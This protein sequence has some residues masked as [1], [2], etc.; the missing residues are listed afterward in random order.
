MKIGVYFLQFEHN[1]YSLCLACCESE[2]CH[3]RILGK[4]GTLLPL[5]CVQW[6]LFM[7]HRSTAGC[8]FS[9]P[10]RS[11]GASCCPLMAFPFPQ[12]VPAG[13]RGRG[14]RSVSGD[15]QGWTPEAGPKKLWGGAGGAAAPEGAS[16]SVRPRKPSGRSGQASSVRCDFQGTRGGRAGQPVDHEPTSVRTLALRGKQFSNLCNLASPPCAPPFKWNVLPL[17]AVIFGP[18]C[19]SLTAVRVAYWPAGQLSA[20]TCSVAMKWALAASAAETSACTCCHV[21]PHSLL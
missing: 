5:K 1:R 2:N 11:G 14:V 15:V 3:L 6:Q 9:G 7:G 19:L 4:C 8:V 21:V 12:V 18:W 10:L 20:A 13:G 17:V 16:Q